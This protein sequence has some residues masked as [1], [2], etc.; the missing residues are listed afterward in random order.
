MNERIEARI[1]AM[2]DEIANL[3][4]MA[5]DAD[6]GPQTSDRRGMVKL[7]GASAVGAVAGA[8][9]FHAQRADAA[10]G[11]PVLV[12]ALNTSTNA[13]EFEAS[14]DHAVRAFGEGGVGIVSD[15]GLANARFPGSGAAPSSGGLR[16]V[17]LVD[18]AG[19]WWA[20]T[21]DSNVDGGWRKLA[22]PNTAGQLHVLPSPVRV[23][24]SR[25]GEAPTAIGPKVPTVGNEVRIIDTT[26][27]GSGVPANARAVLI[28]LTITGPQGPGF[29]SAWPTGAFPGTSSIN[30]A[31]GQSIAA[32]TVVG[33]GPSAKIQF[34]TN[35]VSDFLVDVIGFYR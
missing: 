24:D 14:G 25:P 33:C 27:N 10:D 28:N 13:T 21:L 23:Y 16:G 11:D 7:L 31:A 17:L 9:I 4:E 5:A 29:G 1:A 18:G 19:D 12:G 2:E 30:F 26:A 34:L 15:G 3:K 32:T 22:G 6:E 35:T 20:A 8:A